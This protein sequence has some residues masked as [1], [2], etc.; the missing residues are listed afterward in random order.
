MPD[1]RGRLKPQSLVWLTSE[2]V[3]IKFQVKFEVRSSHLLDV[4]AGQFSH[5]VVLEGQ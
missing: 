3:S 2:E 4:L 1:Y 5:H